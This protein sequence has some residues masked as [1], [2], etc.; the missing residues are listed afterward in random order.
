M[1]SPLVLVYNI[2]VDGFTLILP[3]F[4]GN[5]TSVD[6]GDGS[7]DSSDV[8]TH[9]YISPGIYTVTVNGTILF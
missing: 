8:R 4:E 6:W 2:A 1:S 9:T 5:V 7:T 3:L